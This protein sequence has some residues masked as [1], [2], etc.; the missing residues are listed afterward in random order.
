MI[1]T[2]KKQGAYSLPKD[3]KGAKDYGFH[4]DWLEKTIANRIEYADYPASYI[5]IHG[6]KLL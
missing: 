6:K 4:E 5:S 2:N 3:N 1:K